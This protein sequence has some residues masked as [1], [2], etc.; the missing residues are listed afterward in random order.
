M[1]KKILTIC[2]CLFIFGCHSERKL[3]TRIDP[4]SPK[5]REILSIV[6]KERYNPYIREITADV[7]LRE[8]EEKK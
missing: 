3:K 8:F 1:F 5:Y 4:N 6:I 2:L 7:V